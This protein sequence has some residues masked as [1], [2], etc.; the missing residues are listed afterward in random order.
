[1]EKLKQALYLLDDLEVIKELMNHIPKADIELEDSDGLDILHHAI[2]VNYGEVVQLLFMQGLFSLPSKTRHCPSY[3]HLSCLLGRSYIVNILLDFRPSD[4]YSKVQQDGWINWDNLELGIDKHFSEPKRA[5]MKSTLVIAR[6]K[7]QNGTHYEDYL[8]LDIAVVTGHTNVVK[9]LLSC[10]QSKLESKCFLE[11]AVKMNSP[12]TLSMLLS[13]EK[14][15][16]E[17]LDE[18]VRTALRRKEPECLRILLKHGANIVNVFH[19]LNPYHV[20]YMYSSAYMAP[21]APSR[22]A[23]MDEC[24]SVLLSFKHNI[25]VKLPLGSYPLYSLIHSL[26]SEKDQD[27]STVPVYHIKTFRLLLQAGADPNYNEVEH[28][29]SM[30][31][32][33]RMMTVGRDLFTSGLNA[34][35]VSLQASDTWRPLM[36]DHLNECCLLLL[37]Y[38]AQPNYTDSYGETPLHDLMKLWAMQHA[39]GHM[40]ADLSSMMSMLLKYGADPNLQSTNGLY[41]VHYYFKILFNLMGGVIAYERWKTYNKLTKVLRLLK[42]MRTDDAV[43]AYQQI[44]ISCAEANEEGVPDG[45]TELICEQMRDIV[46]EPRSLQCLCQL[47]IWDSTSRRMHHMDELPLPNRHITELKCLFD[48]VDLEEYCELIW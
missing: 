24:T 22:N 13:S 17:I 3:I 9:L 39:L 16:Q 36:K 27:P 38:G 28:A 26:V 21:G 23:G 37:M 46:L 25:N 11:S 40:H 4:Y 6:S 31:N 33:T 32:D 29:N 12:R 7:L 2:L 8:P 1:M 43:A 15:D 35:F 47:T 45:I 48:L 19:G 5:L 34:F 14:H 30:L 44:L 18:A 20:M 42:L 41:P 10:A